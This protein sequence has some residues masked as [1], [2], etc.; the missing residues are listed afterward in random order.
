ML[1]QAAPEHVGFPLN[2]ALTEILIELGG[3]R[4]RGSDRKVAEG[5]E[6][7]REEREEK[8]TKE[9]DTSSPCNIQKPFVMDDYF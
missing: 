6:I 5:R 4:K 3:R 7:D 1:W 9:T 2:L 8:K